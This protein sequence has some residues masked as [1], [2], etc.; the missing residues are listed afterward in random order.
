M[1]RR[2][3]VFLGGNGH[4]P[5]RLTLARDALA[6]AGGT[7]ELAELDVPG[8]FGRAR[9]HTLDEMLA[10]LERQVHEGDALVYATGRRLES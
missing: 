6:A 1:I 5:G 10:A 7:F 3:V 8:F 9:A 4:C 2:R